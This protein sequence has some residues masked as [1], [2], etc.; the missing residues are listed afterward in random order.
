MTLQHLI[1]DPCWHLWFIH[2][3]TTATCCGSL[4]QPRYHQRLVLSGPR[5]WLMMSTSPSSFSLSSHTPRNVWFFTMFSIFLSECGDVE[6]WALFCLQLFTYLT[7]E[8]GQARN[9]F[10]ETPQI[11]LL[12]KGTQEE[13]RNVS[14]KNVGCPSSLGFNLNLWADLEWILR[15][16][17]GKGFWFKKERGTWHRGKVERGDT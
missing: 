3:V 4:N 14:F 9:Y 8:R 16:S 15:Q 12:Q 5:V 13:G 1:K 17:T 10:T 2:Q 11:Q 7:E 6:K